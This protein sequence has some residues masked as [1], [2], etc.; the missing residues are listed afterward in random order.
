MFTVLLPCNLRRPRSWPRT[1]TGQAALF[2]AEPATGEAPTVLV[3]DD[4]R[5]VRDLL[6]RFLEKE[7]FRVVTAAVSGEEGLRLA[8]EHAPVAHHAR[9]RDAG[10]G[11]LGR[12]EGAQGGSRRWPASR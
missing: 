10:A 7:G 11:R 3:I 2:E 12:A 8:R 4:D 5:I 1:R 9:H 6:L